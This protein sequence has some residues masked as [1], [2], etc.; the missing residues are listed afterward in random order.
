MSLH[1]ENGSPS[2]S[3]IQLPVGRNDLC[4]DAEGNKSPSLHQRLADYLCQTVFLWLCPSRLG[5]SDLSQ[6]ALLF[7]WEQ[8]SPSLRVGD[9]RQLVITYVWPRPSD[10]AIGPSCVIPSDTS[11]RFVE[12]VSGKE[13]C[14]EHQS[15]FKT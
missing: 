12:I 3:R 1:N 11:R 13:N 9:E 8:I 5:V 10:S 15:C 7:S 6:L 14:M 2:G 4:C